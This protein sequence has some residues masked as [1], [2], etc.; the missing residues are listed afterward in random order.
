MPQPVA[1]SPQSVK[2]V[3]SKPETP[4]ESELP[5]MG[6]SEDPVLAYLGIALG[7]IGTLTYAGTRK[8]R[9]N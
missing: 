5:Q 7:A 3:D 8:K 6:D 4:K 2:V 9:Y 1:A